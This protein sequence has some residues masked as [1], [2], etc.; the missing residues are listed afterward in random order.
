MTTEQVL[1]ELMRISSITNRSINEIVKD[2]ESGAPL[3]FK[4]VPLEALTR[5]IDEIRARDEQEK[6]SERL[7]KP[8]K[9][10]LFVE[11]GSVDCKE[12]TD[13]LGVKNPEIKVVVYRAGAREPE[14]K[15]ITD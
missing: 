10:F 13:I 15:A 5:F 14:L 4:F 3:D 12:L 8:I 11:D 7:K 1:T 6:E 9:N 2:K